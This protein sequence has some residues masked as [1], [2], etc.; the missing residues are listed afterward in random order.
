MLVENFYSVD[1]YVGFG[2]ADNC[3]GITLESINEAGFPFFRHERIKGKT[4]ITG[5]IDEHIADS[6][7]AGD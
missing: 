1:Y 3:F 5:D 7:V 2:D 6:F 4:I